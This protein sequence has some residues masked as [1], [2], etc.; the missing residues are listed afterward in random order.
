MINNDCSKRNGELICLIAE[1]LFS[2]TSLTDYDKTKL[3]NIVEII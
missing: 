1:Q 3:N 2:S